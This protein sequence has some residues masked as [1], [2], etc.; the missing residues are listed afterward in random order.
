MTT[1]QVDVEIKY[2]LH[3]LLQDVWEGITTIYPEY[4]DA[5]WPYLEFFTEERAEREGMSKGPHY[6]SPDFSDI[7]APIV[8][9]PQQPCQRGVDFMGEP[10]EEGMPHSIIHEDCGIGPNLAHELTHHLQYLRGE[11]GLGSSGDFHDF[12]PA[13]DEARF[14]EVALFWDFKCGQRWQYLDSLDEDPELYDYHTDWFERLH[15]QAKAHRMLWEK[16]EKALAE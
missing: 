13:E 12:D 15:N 5:E 3:L 4:R 14:M 6:T 1:Q 11:G 7:D 8:R 16:L 10:Y 9:L 2:R